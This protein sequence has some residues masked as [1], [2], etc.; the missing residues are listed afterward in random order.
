[1]ASVTL[2]SRAPLRRVILLSD[3]PPHEVLP[4]LLSL[5]ADLKVEMPTA[6]VLAA[7][8]DLAPDLVVVDAV[9][10][11]QRARE[12]LQILISAGSPVAVMAVLPRSLA[13]N[14]GWE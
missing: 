3:R 11:P 6:E 12:L 14:E 9:S 2:A 10:E 13:E 4:A 5:E 7:L 1:M 8:P